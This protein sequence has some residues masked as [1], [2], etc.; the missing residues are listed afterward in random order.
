V[1]TSPLTA[2]N[3]SRS[4]T[5]GDC[6]PPPP[7]ARHGAPLPD[8][9][10]LQLTPYL[11]SPH[12]TEA[13]RPLPLAQN[14]PECRLRRSPL[15]PT[16]CSRCAATTDHPDLNSGHLQVRTD[17][18]KFPCPSTLAAGDHRRR[19]WPVKPA[20]PL[21]TA[22]DLGLKESKTQGAVCEARDSNE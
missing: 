21:T 16:A 15:P 22:K 8:L 20:P 3:S 9:P 14:S 7:P 18:V 2:I 4:A 5:T 17:L 19:I 1:L 10:R 6:H 11:A 13:S 12:H